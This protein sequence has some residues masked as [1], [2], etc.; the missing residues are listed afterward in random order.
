MKNLKR[1]E[2]MG[3]KR[4]VLFYITFA[5]LLTAVCYYIAA[6]WG[7]F[8]T[9]LGVLRPIFLGLAI[10]FVLNVPMSFLERKLFQPLARR[11]GGLWRKLCRPLSLLLTLVLAISAIVVIFLII[12][13]R[14]IESIMALAQDMPLYWTHFYNWAN[15]LITFY[16]LDAVLVEKWTELSSRFVQMAVDFLKNLMPGLFGFTVGVAS[17]LTNTIF[18]FIFAIYMLLGK[19]RLQQQSSDLLRAFCSGRVCERLMHYAAVTNRCFHNFV[20]GQCVEAI[21]LGTLTYLGVLALQMPYALVIGV[22]IGVS[23]LV[24]IIGAF[25][26]TIPCLILLAIIKPIDALVFLI[27]IIILQ[28]IE[29]NLIYP[30][31]VGGSVGLSGIWVLCGV[32]VGG[33][34]FGIIGILLGVPLLAATG[35]IL[36]E[37]VQRRKAERAAATEGEAS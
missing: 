26:G 16:N 21:I 19:E 36:T 6:I 1:I 3:A 23:S 4:S 29:G 20:S 30:R 22:I 11:R 12:L 35:T 8:T 17:G 31:V 18:G 9:L 13:P 2:K 15:E 25:L 14:F 10:A 37:A 24:P 28:Q 34:L 33:G 32:V 27:F 7:G 5:I